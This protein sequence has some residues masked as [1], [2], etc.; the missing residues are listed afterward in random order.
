MS[1]PTPTT[2]PTP[3]DASVG[4][5]IATVSFK[6][7]VLP[8]PGRG[9]D[10]ALRVTVPQTGERLPV[11]VFSHGFGFSM[12]AYGPIG[13]FWASHGFVVLQPT[14]LDSATLGLAPD[15]P[16]TPRIWRT[17]VEDLVRTLDGL[18]T[19]EEAI[20]GL[21]GRVDHA[22]VAAAGHSYGATTASAL[23]GARVL[24]SEGAVGEDMTDPRFTAGVLL[25]L[26]GTG[27]PDLTAFAAQVFP[28]MNPNFEAMRAAALIVG[29]D[30]DQ[31]P[32]STRG[33]DWWTDAYRLSPAGK[34]MLTLLG[35]DHALGGVHAYG[36]VP[37]TP[38]ENPALLAVVRQV[39][40]AF[41]RTALG[42]DEGSF[43]VARGSL[44]GQAEPAG[45]LESN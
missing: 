45:H 2:A 42:V 34:H 16:R 23:L 18:E 8:A 15:D 37:M 24:D 39:T 36:T 32:L 17:R 14:H 44:A 4:P 7:V 12:D 25:A 9:D 35:A 13:D 33:P 5:A 1:S 41:L 10:L 26:A 29:G 40:T 19:V 43:A 6:P 11:I 28:F 27:G 38:A 20:P 30:Q 3:D 22:R 21:Q 31:S